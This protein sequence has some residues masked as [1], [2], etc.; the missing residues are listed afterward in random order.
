MRLGD[1]TGLDVIEALKRQRPHA[2][3]IVLTGYGNIA[4]AVTSREDGRRGLSGEAR[5]CGRR[6]GG[7]HRQW[8]PQADPT[9]NPMSADRVRWSISSACTSSAVA[10]SRR[11]PAASPCTAARSSAFS[12]S[13]RRADMTEDPPVVPAPDGRADRDT[14]EAALARAEGRSPFPAGRCTASISARG[15]I[16]LHLRAL[17][18]AGVDFSACDLSEAAFRNSDFNNAV[19]R[20]TKLASTHFSDC[21]LTASRFRPPPPSPSSSSAAC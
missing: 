17:P 8:R 21:K 10:T 1:G 14:I 19:F 13:A 16:R 18:R 11:R 9:E 5:R 4:T 3:A 12:P 6:D 2:R 15:S 20:R 7:P